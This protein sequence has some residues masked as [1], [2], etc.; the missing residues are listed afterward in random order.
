MEND[1][2]NF[3]AL[4][5]F[6]PWHKPC[7]S[8]RFGSSLQWKTIQSDMCCC[9]SKLSVIFLRRSFA[10]QSELHT[11]P[12]TYLICQLKALMAYMTNCSCVQ[13]CFFFFFWQK[14]KTLIK[15]S[16]GVE[17]TFDKHASHLAWDDRISMGWFSLMTPTVMLC[18]PTFTLCEKIL[19]DHKHRLPPKVQYN[20]AVVYLHKSNRWCSA[21]QQQQVT[22]FLLPAPGP[23]SSFMLTD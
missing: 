12:Y 2:Q 9:H 22:L 10:F 5:A 19:N 18:R 11:V 20:I 16:I 13:N 21:A 23:A 4:L 1:R 17:H 7:F 15:D 14:A 3:L 8:I 6:L